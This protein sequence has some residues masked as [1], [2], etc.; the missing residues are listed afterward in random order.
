M[1]L[2]ELLATGAGRHLSY[3]DG[4]YQHP[5]GQQRAFIVL[6]DGYQ[7]AFFR[8]DDYTVL[9]AWD[10]TVLEEGGTLSR[11]CKCYELCKRTP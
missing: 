2:E 3:W 10:G 1:T 9:A 6:T 8:L 11:P 7:S 5:V 4:G